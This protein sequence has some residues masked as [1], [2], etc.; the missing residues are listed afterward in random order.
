KAGEVLSYL[1]ERVPAPENWHLQDKGMVDTEDLT[2]EAFKKKLDG[3]NPPASD[4]A[5]S[6]ASHE[7]DYEAVENKIFDLLNELRKEQDVPVLKKNENLKK[8]ADERALETEELFSHTRPDGTEPFTVL[9]E[10]EH[11]YSYRMA[12]E[13]LGMATYFQSEEKM[14]EL[15][16]NGWVESKGHY[17]NMINPDFREVG[18]GVHYDGETLYATQ[19]FGTP[20]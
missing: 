18:I 12:G 1:V 17:E 4:S 16:F 15:L 10:P 8:A 2:T 13:N 14:A 11:E 19:L 20:F 7:I 3:E 9:T 6:S 5:D